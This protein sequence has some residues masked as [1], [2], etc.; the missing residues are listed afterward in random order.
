ME[1]SIGVGGLS[2]SKDDV[3]TS[4][5]DLFSPPQIENGIARTVNE[6][7]RPIAGTNPD[8]RSFEFLIPADPQKF[9]EAESLLLH[10]RMKV[11]KVDGQGQKSDLAAGE[12][13]S[14][15]NNWCDSLFKSVKVYMGVN[16]ID[17]SDPSSHAY[18]YKS[19]LENHLSYGAAAKEVVLP[20][21]GYDKDTP[22]K[23]DDVGTDTANSGNKKFE[24]KRALLLK[25]GFIDFSIPV[26][27][28][29][30]TIARFIPPNIE[31]QMRFEKNETNFVLMAP[32]DTNTY[33]IELEKVKITIDRHIPSAQV[34]KYYNEQVRAGKKV[35]L[36][37]DRSIVKTY[38]VPT[39]STDLSKYNFFSQS[40]LPEQILI[41]MVE[42][43]AY[44]GSIKQSPYNFQQFNFQEGSL[45]CNGFHEPS[46][47]YVLG[48]GEEGGAE[49]YMAFLRN[50]GVSV[51]DREFSVSMK[52]FLNYGT[53]LLAFDREHDK[54]NRLHRHF[55]D[56][57][58]I[59]INLKVSQPSTSNITVIV[60][61]TYSTELI[62][63]PATNE[64]QRTLIL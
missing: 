28:D 48:A 51:D 3:V 19:Y 16:A 57:G 60:Y 54:C 59:D 33:A 58:T 43:S 20:S 44:N 4:M 11:R 63:D 39:G 12:R 50:T 62:I 22:G 55:H 41:G 61:A 1:T 25:N 23:I 36:P 6:T 9:T 14:L 32:T 64:V 10:G 26:H 15:I 52:D 31:I 24:S 45:V 17:I 38:P 13:V 8:T 34:M 27:S 35:R 47:K 30:C 40:Q 46:Q 53:F 5:F 18:A 29:F 37:M 49:L 7:F 42:S 21:R 2:Q 56:S